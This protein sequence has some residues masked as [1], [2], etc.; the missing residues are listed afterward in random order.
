MLYLS[1]NIV[2]K[3]LFGVDLTEEIARKIEWTIETLMDRFAG[4]GMI[5]PIGLPLPQ[6][7]RVKKALK[8]LDT[9]IYEIIRERRKSGDRGDLISMLIAATGEEGGMTDTQLRDEAITLLIA[10][11][12]TTALALG[13]T[14]DLLGRHPEITER[15]EREIATVLG[16]RAPTAADLPRLKYAD[17][18]VRE[19]MRLYPPVWVI[20]REAIA[21]CR[22]GGYDIEPGTQ[23]LASQWIVHRDPRWFSGPEFFRPERWE[24]DFAK[25][26]PRQAYFPYGGGPRICIGNAFAQMEVVLVLVTIAQRVRLTPT[27]ARVDLTPSAMLL[28]KHGLPMIVTTRS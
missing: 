25:T 7:F 19:S 15:L 5:L 3:T 22:I 11:H 20:G 18:I 8:T 24:N 21:P 13:F 2:A 28:P 17:A 6:N 23:L 10:G 12:E 9:I 27:I 4:L 16:E 26:L 14:F 1:L